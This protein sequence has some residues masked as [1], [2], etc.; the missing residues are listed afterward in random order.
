MG[1]AGL[2]VFLSLCLVCAGSYYVALQME[3]TLWYP[4]AAFFSLESERT[5]WRLRVLGEDFYIS[6][7]VV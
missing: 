3:K 5:G 1:K 7:P 2:I 4:S 6:K